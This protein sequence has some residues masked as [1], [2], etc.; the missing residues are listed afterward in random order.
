[1]T[2]LSLPTKT[3]YFLALIGLLAILGGIGTAIFFY[4]GFFNVAASDPD[5]GIVN[6]SLIQVRKASI[7]RHAIDQPPASFGD[8]AMVQAGA[9]AYAKEGCNTCH[10]EPGVEPAKFT[11]GLNPPPDLREVVND[12]TPA[13][14]YWVIDNGIK[15]T[16][17]PSFGIDK[18]PVRAQKIWAIAAF[19]KKLSSVSDENFKAWTTA[20]VGGIGD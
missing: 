19:L 3:F 6:W 17:M 13:E 2:V 12:L 20:P 14:I 1:M 5:P 15:M 4:G 18:P 16:A 11:E 9:F 7:A 10:G 8:P